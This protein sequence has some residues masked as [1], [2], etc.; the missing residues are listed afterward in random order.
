MTTSDH[1][2]ALAAAEQ[3]CKAWDH[4]MPV[5]VL[6][7]VIEAYM[8]EC[9]LQKRCEELVETNRKLHRRLQIA[10][11]VCQ[12]ADDYLK[13]WISVFSAPFYKNNDRRFK[14]RH[15]LKFILQDLRHRVSK[16]ADRALP[17][18]KGETE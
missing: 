18:S 5:A 14:E 4:P 9:P 2:R 8:R 6:E 7:K 1:E 16:L 3:A 11:A 12:S 10:E 13:M 15:F 17:T